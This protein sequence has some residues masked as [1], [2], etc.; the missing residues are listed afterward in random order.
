MS[1]K[2]R[3]RF[4]APEKVAIL[5]L[6]LLEH[7]PVSDLCDQHGIHPTMFYRWQKEFFEN[8]AAAFE[9][10]SRRPSDDKD[11]RIALLEQKLQR[12]HEVLSELMEEH[13]KLKKKLG[14]LGTESGFPSPSAM[15]SS[16]SSSAWAGRTNLPILLL[17]G[18]LGIAMS[19]F[20]RW[21]GR[22]GT[23][24]QHNASL[25]RDFWLE[26]WET[27]AI[28]AFHALYPLEGYRRLAYMMLDA[29]VVAVSPS[30]V[31]RVL[32]AAGK[33]APRGGKPSKKGQGFEQPLRPHEHWHIDVSYLNVCG[34]FFF[35]CSILDGYSRFVI[36]WEIRETMKEAEVE[37]I[38]QR[39]RE[40][41][42]GEQPRI[43][44]DNGP[45]FI[46]RDF[47]EFIRICGMTHVRTSPFYPQSNGKIERWFKTLKGGCI[48]VKRGVT[49]SLCKFA[50]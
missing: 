1:K 26:D 27:A 16:S 48:R 34:T 9:H 14:E 45:Q 36:H 28:I 25:P 3:N 2:T 29:D 21:S 37:T 39:A 13:I 18:W 41:Y 15:R 32:R 42:P 10:R 31:Y 49:E 35:L 47:K 43:I 50:T 6:H 38:I 44:S 5:R 46:A 30:S 4:S 7:T 22:L 33:L 23:P 12:K 20:S 19:K 8:A 40:H 24:N 11:R 17:V